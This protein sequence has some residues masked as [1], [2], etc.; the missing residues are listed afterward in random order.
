MKWSV[1][2]FWLDDDEDLLDEADEEVA[3][4]EED[5]DDEDVEDDVN[6]NDF[7]LPIFFTDVVRLTTLAC[8]SKWHNKTAA[9]NGKMKN[10]I[11]SK[12]RN[13]LVLVPIGI[14]SSQRTD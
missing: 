6:E 12:I 9:T 7:L 14:D 8:A 4:D 5:A 2:K 11:F 3:D 13:L 1:Q 10:F